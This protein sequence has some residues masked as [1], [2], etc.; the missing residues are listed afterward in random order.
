MTCTNQSDSASAPLSHSSKYRSDVH[1]TEVMTG[2]VL[3]IGKRSVKLSLKSI[4]HQKKSDK[5]LSVYQLRL[6]QNLSVAYLQN[7]PLLWI[8]AGLFKTF[9]SLCLF[10]SCCPTLVWVEPKLTLK[11]VKI[12]AEL[13]GLLW[14]GYLVE[15]YKESTF[16]A[17]F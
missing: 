7:V 8:A 17:R 4:K 9:F 14:W 10:R 3:P 13:L 1:L 11:P 5:L 6:E 16:P 12:T 15:E 2:L